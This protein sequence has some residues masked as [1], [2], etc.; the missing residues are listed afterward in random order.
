VPS[1]SKDTTKN[2]SCVCDEMYIPLACS[3]YV[4][5]ILNLTFKKWDGVKWTGLLCLGIGTGGRLL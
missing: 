1:S 3:Y 5:I 4:R 2:Y